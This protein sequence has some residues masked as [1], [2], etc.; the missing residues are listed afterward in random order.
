MTTTIHE[1]LLSRSSHDVG[2]DLYRSGPRLPGASRRGARCTCRRCGSLDQRRS[3]SSASDVF[4]RRSISA[5]SLFCSQVIDATYLQEP[6]TLLAEPRSVCL[7]ARVL[8]FRLVRIRSN[9]DGSRICRILPR[10]D[11]GGAE[12]GH[13]GR[14][15]FPTRSVHRNSCSATGLLVGAEGLEPRPS[16]CK[17]GRICIRA[18]RT[19]ESR[20]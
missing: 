8:P 19:S 15:T 10:R 9:P 11:K 18:A 1:D 5:A 3:A 14:P 6:S 17:G 20:T 7:L 12:Q 4:R 13:T 2:P 16:P